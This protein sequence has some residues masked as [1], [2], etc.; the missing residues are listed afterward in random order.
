MDGAA[1][2]P[3]TRFIS[4]L[5]ITCSS[6]TRQSSTTGTGSTRNPRGPVRGGLELASHQQQHVV[7]HELRGIQQ[8][9]LR[10]IGRKNRASS[11]MTSD[12]RMVSRR[13]HQDLTELRVRRQSPRR[14]CARADFGIGHDCLQRLLTSCARLAGEF[15][16]RTNRETCSELCA[17]Q[18]P[19]PGAAPPAACT[20]SM[21]EPRGPA[22][23]CD[24][25][26]ITTTSAATAASR[27]APLCHHA[28]SSRQ[29]RRR[30]WRSAILVAR[31]QEES[32]TGRLSVKVAKRCPPTSS[33]VDA[34]DAV[35]EPQ[36]LGA[37][38]GHGA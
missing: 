27:A 3:R 16:G 19:A 26:K 7:L 14:P 29:A 24:E 22:R 15:A 9:H 37:T 8:S 28:G 4:R 17:A 21:S 35:A 38:Q 12:A 32:M 1:P 6:W 30:S 25:P 33:T 5:T 2:A 36:A 13:C 11:P 18:T 10:V 34:V 31:L 23:G 20:R